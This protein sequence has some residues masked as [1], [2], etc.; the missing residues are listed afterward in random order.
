MSKKMYDE[1]E[2]LALISEVE[3]Q[4]AEHLAKSESAVTEPIS[5]KEP[6]QAQAAE[7]LEKSEVEYDEQDFKE[8]D[9]MYKSMKKTEAEIHYKSVKKAL[10]GDS[11]EPTEMKKTEANA[12]VSISKSEFDSLKKS[13]DDLKKDLE[14]VT[15]LLKKAFSKPEVKTAPEQKAITEIQYLK[16]TEETVETKK[17]EKDVSKLSKSEINS[18]LTAQIKTGTLKKSDTDAISSY[19]AKGSIDSIKHLL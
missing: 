9:D 10:F 17:D 1:K 15:S 14:S 7:D 13:N 2:L 6:V 8:M 3:T 5:K 11:Q 16:K 4:F 12:E 19:F 18:K